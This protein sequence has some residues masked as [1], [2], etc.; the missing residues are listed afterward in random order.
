MKIIFKVVFLLCLSLNCFPQ[1][2]DFFGR[3]VDCPT[4]ND[5]LAVYNNSLKVYEFYEKNPDYVK[6]KSV[7]FKTNQDVLN[8]FYSLQDA[9]KEF[10]QRFELRERVL[11]GENIPSVLLPRN[12]KNIPLSDYYVSIDDYRFF[13]RELENGILNT[14][15]PFPLYDYRIA[16]LVVNSYENRYGKNEFNGD[17]VNIALYI[18]VTVKPYRLLTEEE[19][20]ER[21][22]IL[23]GV[24]SPNII[25]PKTVDKKITPLTEL[26]RITND[27]TILPTANIEYTLPTI[28]KQIKDTTIVLVDTMKIVTVA[29]FKPIPSGAIPIYY[30]NSWGNSWFIGHMVG[31]K[32]RKF[33]PGDEFYWVLP[34]SI[35]DFLMNDEAIKFYL[36]QIYGKYYDGIY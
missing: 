15:S 22:I 21:E 3:N 16:P 29:K 25:K 8:C 10:K 13:Q 19:K 11:N 5:S 24:I 2:L 7:R 4:E 27:T 30:Y 26:K 12:G 33:Q 1:C 32:F 17:F 28:N 20:K 9:V 14:K 23:K 36:E 34:K 35:K 18:P 6:I 31:R